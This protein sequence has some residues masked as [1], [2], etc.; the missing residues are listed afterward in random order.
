MKDVPKMFGLNASTSSAYRGPAPGLAEAHEASVAGNQAMDAL[1]REWLVH[2]NKQAREGHPIPLSQ[3][4]KFIRPNELMYSP[5][6]DIVWAGATQPAL[7]HMGSPLPARLPSYWQR[8]PGIH[9]EG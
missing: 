3:Y 9:D 4:P 2:A 7:V 6:G 5:Q 8:V 1:T